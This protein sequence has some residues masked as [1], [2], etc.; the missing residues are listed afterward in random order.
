[1]H[2]R[3][4]GVIAALFAIARE[5]N[6]LLVSS[7]TRVSNTK[8][9]LVDLPTMLVLLATCLLVA[10]WLR[11]NRGRDAA[12]AGGTFGLLLLRGPSSSFCCP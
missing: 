8:T 7:E 5:W 11:S 9:L 6:T 12:L 4:A 1:L 10:R 2:S 3:E